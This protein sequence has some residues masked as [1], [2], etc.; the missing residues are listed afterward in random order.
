[1]ERDHF[2]RI[3]RSRMGVQPAAW[4]LPPSTYPPSLYSSV[5]GGNITRSSW[6]PYRVETIRT[7]T[8]WQRQLGGQPLDFVKCDVDR[9][10]REIGVDGLIERRAFRVMA[11]E[12]DI[13]WGWPRKMPDWGVY[14]ADQLVWFAR[15]HGYSAYL[16]VPCQARRW[17]H[18]GVA[19]RGHGPAAARVSR[20]AASYFPLANASFFA[21]T[22]ATL[23]FFPLEQVHDLI[24]LDNSSPELARLPAMAMAAC[25]ER[26]LH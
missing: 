2:C 26:D 13:S 20:F 8:L 19:K 10:W 16:K 23:K 14:A 1:M 11:I 21:P 18:Y 24:L 4:P 25:R 15:R 5:R 7:E 12:I 3:V 6:P 17:L 22:G 9:S